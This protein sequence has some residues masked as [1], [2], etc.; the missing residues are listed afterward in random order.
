[1]DLQ[2]FHITSV[3]GLTVRDVVP[4]LTGCYMGVRVCKNVTEGQRKGWK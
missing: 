4:K 3:S 1:M 2:Q